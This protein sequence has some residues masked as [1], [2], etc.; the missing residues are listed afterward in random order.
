MAEVLN[1]AESLAHLLGEGAMPDLDRNCGEVCCE[2]GWEWDVRMRDF[3]MWMVIAGHGTAMID[4]R[5]YPLCAGT[6]LL[7]RPGL[8]VHATQ[9]P[10]RR[11]RVAYA[12]FQMI[13]PS[14]RRRVRLVDSMLPP[15]C[16]Q[17]P[18]SSPAMSLMREIIALA[19]RDG[20][21]IPVARAAR[22]TVVLT[23]LWL[24]GDSGAGLA[25]PD[26]RIAAIM[27]AIY[28]EPGNRRGLAQAADLVNL[29]PRHFSRLFRKAAGTSYRNFCLS[30]RLERA[31]C[32]LTETPMTVTAIARAL[33]YSDVYL[34]SRQIRAQFGQS[35][36][37]LRRTSSSQL[38]TQTPGPRRSLSEP[39][40]HVE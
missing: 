38:T 15:V 37:E 22:L 1:A 9:D 24:A 27:S 2:P 8:L 34:M 25:E 11:L 20:P 3:D 31:R 35:P 16:T 23:E 17:V 39:V 6:I 7:L 40:R 21:L 33:G 19:Q 30:A 28:S 5:V 10:S 32:L 18:S 29:G 12:H 4:G 14:T 26:P 36:R 13:N